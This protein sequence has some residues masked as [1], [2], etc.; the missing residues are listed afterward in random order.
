MA[1]DK[2]TSKQKGLTGSKDAGVSN[3]VRGPCCAG[4][5]GS[6]PVPT[7]EGRAVFLIPPVGEALARSRSTAPVP[8]S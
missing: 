8:W 4:R 1:A 2:A 7:T 3:R 6:T 5:D